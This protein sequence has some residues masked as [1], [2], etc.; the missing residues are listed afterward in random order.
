MCSE[1]GTQSPKPT[2]ASRACPRLALAVADGLAKALQAHR[3]RVHAVQRGQRGRHAQVRGSPLP[4]T[5]LRQRRVGEDAPLPGAQ[6]NQ[7]GYR[8]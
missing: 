5:Q 6:D 7:S 4:L 3:R 8:V 2:K 1:R